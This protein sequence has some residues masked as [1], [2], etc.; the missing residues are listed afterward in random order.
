ME[1]CEDPSIWR[2]S[3]VYFFI[4][5]CIVRVIFLFCY[6]KNTHEDFFIIH[7]WGGEWDPHDKPFWPQDVFQTTD[8][9]SLSNLSIYTGFYFYV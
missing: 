7:S 1:A 6:V 2:K 3:Y 4:N 9:W 5:V 8:N